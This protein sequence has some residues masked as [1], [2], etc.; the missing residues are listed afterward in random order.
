MTDSNSGNRNI[1]VMFHQ[2]L[3]QTEQAKK[4]KGFKITSENGHAVVRVELN[5]R[6]RRFKIKDIHTLDELE[7]KLNKLIAEK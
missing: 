1:H 2:L 3:L 4:I 6:S 7:K 5:G